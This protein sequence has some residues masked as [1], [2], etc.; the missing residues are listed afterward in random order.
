MSDFKTFA[1]FITNDTI[2]NLFRK[3][4][5]VEEWSRMYPMLFD[6]DD[7][8]IARS[9]SEKSKAHYYEW[10]AAIIL[11]HTNG[12]LSLNQKYAYRSHSRKLEVLE[13]LTIGKPKTFEFIMDRGHESV[14]QLPDLL[15]YKKD[16]KSW[17]FAEVKGP[18]DELRPNQVQLF[19]ELSQITRKKVV[20]VEFQAL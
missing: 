12:L 9:Q 15:V 18:R 8:R 7:T 13:K 16:Y 3:G 5:L 6:S 19:N 20:I 1:T 11:Y 14:T 10:L 17:F 2:R 4:H